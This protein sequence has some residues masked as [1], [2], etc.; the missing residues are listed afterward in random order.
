MGRR[1]ESSDDAE[2]VH[3][4][5]E[6]SGC[7]EP[8][9]DL[10]ERLVKLVE[11]PLLELPARIV[12][13]RPEQVRADKDASLK[14]QHIVTRIFRLGGDPGHGIDEAPEERAVL[15]EHDVGVVPDIEPESAWA[16]R[17][18]RVAHAEER[19]DASRPIDAAVEG[20]AVQQPLEL[21]AERVEAG[22]V[23]AVEMADLGVR[24]G[25]EK[26]SQRGAKVEAD[27]GVLGPGDEVVL[28][29]QLDDIGL[30][31]CA[32]T[33]G[34]GLSSECAHGPPASPPWGRCKHTAG[35]PA[36]RS[37]RHSG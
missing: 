31:P 5:A 23:S 25:S 20:R 26:A 33:L 29:E 24:L 15:A 7:I 21:M 14:Q 37:T 19:R 17:A 13:V 35:G 22:D 16:C 32:D 2:R 11:H 30:P 27:A 34:R 9:D 18:A 28:V 6:E 3:V 12:R 10:P 4:E 1:C 8:G 36:N